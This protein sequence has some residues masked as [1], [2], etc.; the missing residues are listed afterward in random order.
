M[1]LLVTERKTFSMSRNMFFVLKHNFILMICLSTLNLLDLITKTQN[2]LTTNDSCAFDTK[3]SIRLLYCL[4]LCIS[5][6]S[7]CKTGYRLENAKCMF[8]QFIFTCPAV[9]CANNFVNSCLNLHFF[10]RTVRVYMI[11]KRGKM[12]YSVISNYNALFCVENDIQNEWGYEVYFNSF[13]S[14]SRG[15]AIFKQ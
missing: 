7:L 1:L 11:L 8:V 13:S 9:Y 14:K 10:P 6:L 4:W 15:V 2:N 12:Y 5:F 3:H